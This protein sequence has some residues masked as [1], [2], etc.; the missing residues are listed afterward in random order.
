MRRS[1]GRV[2]ECTLDVIATRKHPRDDLHQYTKN[3]RPARV[4]TY[5]V[6]KY[7]SID[8]LHNE[9]SRSQNDH[10]RVYLALLANSEVRWEDLYT[11]MRTLFSLLS[12]SPGTVLIVLASWHVNIHPK[13]HLYRRVDLNLIWR[14]SRA[15]TIAWLRYIC[16][17]SILL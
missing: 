7:V 13:C 16:T 12:Q 17:L 14:Q 3:L 2:A 8:I 1:Y 10:S 11:D 5:W 4:D 6:Q 15:V 9:S